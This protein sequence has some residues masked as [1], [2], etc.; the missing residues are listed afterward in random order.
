MAVLIEG[1]L[2]VL[3]KKTLKIKGLKKLF[4]IKNTLIFQFVQIFCLKL[5]SPPER[6]R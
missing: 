6:G 4:K 2:F 1:A 3:S 5:I